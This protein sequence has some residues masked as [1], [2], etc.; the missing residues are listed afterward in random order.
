[1]FGRLGVMSPSVWWDNQV[2]LRDVRSLESRPPASVWLDVG[3]AEREP[4][5]RN[6]KALRDALTR[7]G[8]KLGTDLTYFELPGGTHDEESFARR[9]GDM[10]KF[11]F[12][13][14]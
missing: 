12:P 11:L 1:V 5:P 13:A 8:W 4:T 10:L 14:R 2:I 6:V 7:K 9:A 3:A